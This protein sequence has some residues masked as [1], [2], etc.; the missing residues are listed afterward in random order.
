MTSNEVDN[1]NNEETSENNIN[2]D[3]TLIS[4]NNNETDSCSDNIIQEIKSNEIY[5]ITKDIESKIPVL[6]AYLK[7]KS[8]PI[9]NKLIIIKYMRNL[10]TKVKFNS[11]IFK[12]ASEK[13]NIYKVIINQYILNK[14]EEEEYL[15]ELKDLFFYYYLK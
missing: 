11:E 4:P 15:K 10:F 7:N 5:L 12:K 2:S 3:P 9:S 8:N 13:I 6:L 14:K 1:N